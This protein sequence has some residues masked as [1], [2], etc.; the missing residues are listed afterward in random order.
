MNM[1]Q[2]KFK[3][4]LENRAVNVVVGYDV[5]FNHYFYNIYNPIAGP[6]ED[7]VVMSSLDDPDADMGGG[8][9]S[10][11]ILFDKLSIISKYIP[12]NLREL[13]ELR[14]GNKIYSL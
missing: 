7:D 4:E 1:S 2:I 10:V 14:E 8:Y 5:P 6:D 9:A 13:L 3:A 11:D 12:D